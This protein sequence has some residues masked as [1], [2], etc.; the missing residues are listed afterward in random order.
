MRRPARRAPRRFDEDAAV[1]PLINV[2][3]LLLIFFMV[4]GRLSAADPFEIE[5]AASRSEAPAGETGRLVLMGADGRLALDGEAMSR[6]ALLARLSGPDA[7]AVRI[8]ADGRAEA[9]RLVALLQALGARG[10]DEARLL[11]VPAAR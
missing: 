10:V 5:P 9:A 11:T 8:K 4:A 3:F 7:G 2:V 6:E 1:L